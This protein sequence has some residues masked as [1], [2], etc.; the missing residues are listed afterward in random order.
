MDCT[1]RLEEYL[2]DCGVPFDVQRHREAFTAQE[3]AASEH[4]HGRRMAKVVMVREDGELVML[5]VPAPSMVDL[6]KAG[7]VIGRQVRLAEEDEF[8]PTFADCQPGAMPPFGNLY[9][10]PVV[11]D[12][13]VAGCETMVFQ[14]GTHTVTMSLPYADF[15]RLVRPRVDDIVVSR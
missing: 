15:E 2:R 11:V 4:V 14:A 5:V 13:S 9:E 8:A 3:V 1:T 12:E 10:V 6:D 7:H